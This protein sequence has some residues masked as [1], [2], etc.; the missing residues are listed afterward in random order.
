MQLCRRRSGRP[1]TGFSPLT[2]VFIL[3]GTLSTIGCGDDSGNGN[4]HDGSLD[5]ALDAAGQDDAQARRDSGQ[6]AGGDADVDGGQEEACGTIVT[7]ETDKHPSREI[8]V[9]TDGDDDSGDGSQAHPFATIR[10]A[11]SQADPGTA[12][13]I[14]QGTY[15]GG[16][17]IDG[18]TG[19][20]A[21]PIWIGGAPG[22]QRPLIDGSGHGEAI[23]MTRTAFVILHDLEVADSDDNGIN[24]DDGGD[25]SDPQAT[26]HVVFRNLFLHDVGGNGNQDCLKLSGLNE[27]F[28]LD[29]EITRCGGSQSGSGVDMVGCHQGLLARN[30][31][32]DLSA[33]AFQIKGGCEDIEVRWN[34]IVDGGARGINMGGSTGFQYFRPPLSES[35]P[36]AEARNIRT[37][38]NVIVGGEASIAFV[39]CV[40]CLVINNTI[41]APQRWIF[42]ILQETTTSDG[43]EFLPCSDNLVQNNLIVFDRSQ[44]RTYINIGANTAPQTFVFANNLW[45]AANDP[46]SSE[47]DLPVQ[48]SAGIYG[49]D[50]NLAAPSSN[51]FH[52]P[53]DSP[54]AGSGSWDDILS[55]GDMDGRCYAN[56]PSIGAYDPLGN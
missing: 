53:T 54:A 15:P 56:P 2:L 14:H 32:H 42:R 37:V 18:L 24:C 12:L 52:I 4:P 28:V 13:V 1:M 31:M 17:S 23:H 22:E 44:I 5:A 45:Y 46:S 11:V 35:S 43:Y 27:F 30:S 10:H 47:P 51:D 19:T 21:A 25:M 3:T 36:N 7:F 49:Q 8:H 50:P 26:H 6:D 34:L 40:Q 38:A 41:V 33:N 55:P 39:G 20:E 16:I 9:A 29:N 48:E